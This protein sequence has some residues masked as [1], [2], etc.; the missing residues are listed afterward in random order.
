MG[1][2]KRE[3][4][5]E[6]KVKSKKKCGDWFGRKHDSLCCLHILCLYTVTSQPMISP[7]AKHQISIAP[8]Y[9][10]HPFFQLL[11]SQSILGRHL[12]KVSNLFMILPCFAILLSPIFSKLFAN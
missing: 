12:A 2:E 9:K 7:A 5:E 8:L 11:F 4:S 3:E 1:N 10:I 6:V